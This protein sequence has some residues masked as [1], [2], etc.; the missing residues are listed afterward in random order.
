MDSIEHG[1]ELDRDAA[2]A[3]AAA[4]TTLVSTLGVLHSWLTF[5]STST[6][7][8]FTGPDSRAGIGARLEAAEVGVRLAH[9]AG[10]AV[11][12]GSDFGGGSLRANQ[13]AWEA[14][15]L[16]RAGLPPHEALAALT[17]RGGDLL[18]DP[19]AGRLVVGGPAHFSLVHGDPLSDPACLWRVWLTR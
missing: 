13:L 17:W 3:M 15:S 12:G 19:A 6:V 9:A 4:G 2:G 8:G 7:D 11:A 10:V 14:E 5:T 16:V 1:F 18:G